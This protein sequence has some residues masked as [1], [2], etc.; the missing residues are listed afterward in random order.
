MI[1]SLICNKNI[2]VLIFTLSSEKKKTNTIIENRWWNNALFVSSWI[3]TSKIHIFKCF[4]FLFLIATPTTTASITT[5]SES[6]IWKNISFT[7]FGFIFATV[8][9][10]CLVW[11]R[12]LFCF[13]LFYIT[14]YGQLLNLPIFQFSIICYMVLLTKDFMFNFSDWKFYLDSLWK[15]PKGVLVIKLRFLK[16]NARKTNNNTNQTQ[17]NTEQLFMDLDLKKDMSILFY[18]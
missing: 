11:N 6:S 17:K 2:L 18:W 15:T 1:Y 3:F 5:S 4:H 12:G 7:F 14:R 13:C 10:D 9:E 8:V 16:V